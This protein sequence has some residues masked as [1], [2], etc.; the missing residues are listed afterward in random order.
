MNRNL[1]EN[2]VDAVKAITSSVKKGK[3]NNYLFFEH[4]KFDVCPQNNGTGLGN[5]W[6]IK[7]RKR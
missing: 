7:V 6:A 5:K 1:L 4:Q 3:T 2:Y